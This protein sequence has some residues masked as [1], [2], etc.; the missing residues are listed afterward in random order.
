MRH[1]QSKNP[2]TLCLTG[3]RVHLERRTVAVRPRGRERQILSPLS[4]FV[5]SGAFFLL[6]S[7]SLAF[8]SGDLRG[9]STMEAAWRCLWHLRDYVFA[10][11]RYSRSLARLASSAL[12]ICRRV[13]TFGFSPSRNC[14]GRRDGSRQAE[15]AHNASIKVKRRTYTQRT[16]RRLATES[17]STV[18]C[19]KETIKNDANEDSFV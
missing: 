9:A 18:T 4:S 6:L 8:V 14:E 10:S 5:A 12:V 15:R 3:T 7:L 2:M 11:R 16:S 19:I 1:L 13:L 17:A